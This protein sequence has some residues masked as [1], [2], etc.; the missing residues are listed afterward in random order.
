MAVLIDVLKRIFPVLLGHFVEGI[1]LEGSIEAG[2]SILI[3]AQFP[4]NHTFVVPAQ[5][6]QA[7]AGD[8]GARPDPIGQGSSAGFWPARAGRQQGQL[9]SGMG[10]CSAAGQAL[11]R[12]MRLLAQGLKSAP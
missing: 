2:Q 1:E 9:Q 12:Q 5:R 7:A 3:S 6:I 10:L 8:S 4:K 11:R